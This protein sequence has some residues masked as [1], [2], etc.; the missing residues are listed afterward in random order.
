MTTHRPSIALL[1]AVL[2][3]GAATACGGSGSGDLLDTIKQAGKIKVVTDPAY[4]PQSE[5]LPDGTLEGFDIDVANEIARR[6]GVTAQF[7][8][9]T[10]FDLVQGGGWAGRWD[11]SVGSVTVTEERKANL[12][13][14]QPYYFTPAQMGVVTDSGITSLD[15]LAGKTICTGSGT[16]YQFWIQ[17]TLALGDGSALAPVPQGAQVTTFDTDTQCA[18]AIKSGR[19]DFQAW[20]TASETLVAAIGEGAPFTVVGAPVFYEPL[21]VAIDKKNATHARLMTELD[22]IVAEMHT[23]GTLSNLSKKWYDGRDLTLRATQ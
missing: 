23:D 1:F 5:Q 22:R 18:D 2:L 10:N 20:L 4:P 6:L 16:T 13:F 9:T 12:D 8:P 14:T 15:G 11:I 3:L 19:R 21:A 17:G 7:E